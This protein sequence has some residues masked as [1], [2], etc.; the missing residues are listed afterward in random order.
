M[1][2]FH[3]NV[4][5]F[6]RDI[7][8]QKSQKLSQEQSVGIKFKG[9]DRIPSA[10]KQFKEILEAIGARRVM[11][12]D[13]IGAYVQITGDINLTMSDL[14][15]SRLNLHCKRFKNYEQVQV[16]SIKN[17]LIQRETLGGLNSMFKKL[18][19]GE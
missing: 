13:L 15:I 6:S 19:K 8:H 3:Y 12:R 18:N 17:F 4:L 9:L 5:K 2:K 14:F 11:T 7:V 1:G 10:I 16:H